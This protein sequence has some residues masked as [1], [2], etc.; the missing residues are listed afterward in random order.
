MLLLKI[1]QVLILKRK[2]KLDIELK[3]LN[4]HVMGTHEYVALYENN[5]INVAGR[6]FDF[7]GES[8]NRVFIFKDI[9]TI[10]TVHVHLCLPMK[11]RCRSSS[12]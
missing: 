11:N 3:Q 4:E 10:K 2:K 8:Y 1:F 5:E 9:N 12:R 6:F 7:Y